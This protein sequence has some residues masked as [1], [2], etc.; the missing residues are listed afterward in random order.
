MLRI[1]KNFTEEKTG[2]RETSYCDHI[3]LDGWGKSRG[4][5]LGI[6]CFLEDFNRLP[7]VYSNGMSCSG[8]RRDHAFWQPSGWNLEE[9]DLLLE[10]G[11]PFTFHFAYDSLN[12]SGKDFLDKI[13]AANNSHD[14]E[15]VLEEEIH[16]S[17]WYEDHHN[18]RRL[19]SGAKDFVYKVSIA[20]KDQYYIAGKEFDALRDQQ[21]K[22]LH[23]LIL[24][25]IAIDINV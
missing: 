19:Y 12:P 5:D 1:Y 6:R 21:I 22:N 8:L 10:N 18:Y 9:D 2:Q 4:F 24:H 13:K 15:V 7:F 14:N 23:E 17:Y 3:V 16:P 11:L 25:L 20:R